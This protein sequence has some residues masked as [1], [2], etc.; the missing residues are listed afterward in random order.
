[1]MTIYAPFL[2]F[3]VVKAA[4]SPGVLVGVTPLSMSPD[5]G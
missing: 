3:S 5:P 4:C 1:M 2:L